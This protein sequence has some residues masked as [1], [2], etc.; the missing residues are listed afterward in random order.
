MYEFEFFGV[1]ELDWKSDIQKLLGSSDLEVEVSE[2][3]EISGVVRS[4]D[5]G[6]LSDYRNRLMRQGVEV[7]PVN[8]FGGEEEDM[9]F[10]SSSCALQYLSDITGKRIKIAA[11]VEDGVSNERDILLNKRSRLKAVEEAGNVIDSVLAFYAEPNSKR[12]REFM[13]LLNKFRTLMSDIPGPIE[14]SDF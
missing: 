14:K 10:K 12:G 1:S 2:G 9:E 5:K 13:Q 7:S 6:Y 8:E 3:D 4:D 11:Y